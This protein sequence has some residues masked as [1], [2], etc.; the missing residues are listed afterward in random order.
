M[1][2][3]DIGN[4]A[5][6]G[7]DATNEIVDAWS[8]GRFGLNDERTLLSY[9]TDGGGTWSSPTSISVV[10]DRSAYSAP[11]I[12]PDGTHVYV[13]YMAYGQ[14]FQ[15]TTADPRLEHGVL[16]G[17]GVDANGA[18]TGWTTLYEGAIR[19]RPRH[20]P[21]TDPLQR[22]PGRL[23]VRDRDPHVRG[24]RVDRR[25]ANAG[26]PGDGRLA[27]GLV[28]GRAPRVPG[29]VAAGR[30]P[31]RFREQRHLR[32]D[33]RVAGRPAGAFFTVASARGDPRHQTP[34]RYATVSA[35]PSSRC[36]HGFHASADDAIEM[37]SALLRS[38][39]GGNGPCSGSPSNPTMSARRR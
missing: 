27:A 10:G 29:S 16:L 15:T 14:P 30:L 19:R 35:R 26:L 39:P 3:I 9:S 2:S 37:S 1:P 25:P 28:D 21:G 31:V 13:T 6:T 22:V 17:A 8:D 38:S 7:T 18:P 32:G 33:D 12:S 24:R 4:G 20:V 5:P 23:R 36:V 34:F 11:A